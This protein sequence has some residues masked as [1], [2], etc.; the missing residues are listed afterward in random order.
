[1]GRQGVTV[2]KK[3][4][5]G[6]WQIRFQYPGYSWVKGYTRSLRTTD[7][8]EAELR[9]APLIYKHNLLKEML[10]NWVDATVPKRRCAT[11]E[12]RYKPGRWPVDDGLGTWVTASQDTLMFDRPGCA[13]WSEPNVQWAHEHDRLPLSAH[14]WRMVAHPEYAEEYLAG[15]RRNGFEDDEA[16]APVRKTARTKPFGDELLMHVKRWLTDTRK[17]QAVR[18]ET[19]HAMDAWRV[20]TA[21]KPLKECERADAIRLREFLLETDKSATVQKKVGFLAA[22]LN[23]SAEEHGWVGYNPFKRLVTK[24]FKRALNDAVRTRTFTE[25]DM[26]KV[27]AALATWDDLECVRLW[28]LCATTGM[29]RGEAFLIEGE[30][31]IG[32]GRGVRCIRIV[33]TNPDDSIKN[34]ESERTIPIPADAIPY[35]PAKIEGRLFKGTPKNVG[36]RLQEKLR[37]LGV[38]GPGKTLRST[39]KRAGER[40][41]NIPINGQYSLEKIR[42]EILGHERGGRKVADSVYAGEY[43]KDILKPWIDV[44]GLGSTDHST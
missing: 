27:R 37:K 23:Y 20:V 36:K 25:D 14:A 6:M 10:T 35:L 9:A 7:K 22:A 33:P 17:R 29:R 40:I 16:P 41:Q 18:N 8:P 5:S 43:P 32:A 3:P 12:M 13:P 1:M 39:R 21:G 44:I 38:T 24:K 15:R 26:A 4:D 2:F 28:T 31:R 19:M 30:E 42:Y 34:D 11:L